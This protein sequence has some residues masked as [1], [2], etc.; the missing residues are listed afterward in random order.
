VRRADFALTGQ[1]RSFLRQGLIALLIGGI[2]M[3]LLILLLHDGQWFRLAGPLAF[4]ATGFAALLLLHFGRTRACLLVAT[5]GSWCA[6]TAVMFASNGVNATT[7]ISFP[8]IIMMAGWVIGARTAI[9]I[10]VMSTLALLLVAILSAQGIFVRH[11]PT[12]PYMYWLADTVVFMLSAGVITQL[13]RAHASH[14]DEVRRLTTDLERQRAEA[15]T[16]DRLRH[17]KDLLDRTGRLARVG[18]WEVD[19]ASRQLT[20]TTETFHIHDLEPGEAPSLERGIAYYAPEAQQTIIDAGRK[21][22]AEG[23]PFD[24]E[25]PL[26]TAKKRRIWVRVLGEPHLADG[27]AVRL[28]GAFQDIT[29]HRLAEEKLKDSLNNLQCTL[30]A[31]ADGIFGYDGTNPDDRLLFANRRFFEIWGIADGSPETTTRADIIAAARKLFPDPDAGVQRIKEILAMGVPVED[32]VH[33]NDGRVLFRR[34]VPLLEGSQVSRVWSFRDITAEERA[35]AELAASRDEALRANAAK[36]EFLSRM[37][38]ELRTP[39]HAITGM[40]ALARRRTQDARSMEHLD[41]ARD[42]A[43]H[44]LSVI[45]DILDISKI[46]AGRMELDDVDFRLDDLV[47]T[48]LNLIGNRAEEKGIRLDIRQESSGVELL[49]GDPLRLGQV[50]LNIVSNAVKF[51]AGGTVTI[52]LHGAALAGDRL[53]LRVDVTDQGPGIDPSAVERLFAPFEQA[54]GSM[55]RE[56]GGTGLGLAISKRLVELMGGEIGVNSKPGHGSSFWFTALLGRAT[57]NSAVLAP[58]PL[59][60]EEGL[61]AEFAGSRVLVV[62]DDSM[63]LEVARELLCQ[64]GLTVDAATDGTE[65]LRLAQTTRYALILMDMHMPRMNGT[66]AA[67]AIRANSPNAETPIVAMTANA[68]EEDRRTCLAAGMDDHIGKPVGAELL[69]GTA[70]HWLSR[71]KTRA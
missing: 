42:A 48:L 7:V 6:A 54:D 56:F 16:A 32:K 12:S 53:H 58:A 24:L 51:S 30:Q 60:A 20:W 10:A 44:L 1:L 47:Q 21:A 9:T 63:C 37:S 29:A 27:Q 5:Y 13:R 64:A 65:A 69:F 61:R 67:R 49:R 38:H 26:I 4:V 36:S 43:N 59:P 22:I 33:L 50:L 8:L 68:F 71:R 57:G 17:H 34:S 55:T 15:A 2:G 45:A 40:I 62:D 23:I 35:K 46:E 31:T 19:I 39:M 25:L 41:K 14:V 28:T 11:W 3:A 52:R 70:L 66:E 18:G